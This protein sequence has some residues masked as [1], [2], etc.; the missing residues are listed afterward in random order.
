LEK[1]GKNVKKQKSKFLL[2]GGALCAALAT[3]GAWADIVVVAGAKS[4][5]G[6]LSKEQA[7][8]IYL[9]KSTSLT[10]LDQPEASPLRDEFYTKVTGKSA[11]QAKS[12][13]SKLSFTGKGTPPKEGQN[14]ADIKKQVGDNPALVGYIEKSAVDGTVMVLYRVQ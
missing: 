9:G 14:S 5:A 4:P 13:W 8:D 3:G 1:K 12:H 6:N 11:A 7:S 10:P 2:A